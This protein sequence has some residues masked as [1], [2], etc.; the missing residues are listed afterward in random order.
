MADIQLEIITPEKIAY[1]DKVSMVS[2][3][4]SDGTVGVLPHHVPLFTKLVEG[5]VKILKGNEEIY[6]AIG[7]GFMEVTLNKV[8][9]LVTAAYH[10]DEINEQEVTLAK[11]RAEEALKSKPT[12]E[13][14]IEA[15]NLFR[16]SVVALKVFNK[17]HHRQNRNNL[18][19]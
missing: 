7:G 6:L 13:A 4:S 2:A 14:L 1:T 5:E 15:Q 17:R 11:K 12:G 8:V 3:P 18:V 19:S 9:I 10:A 16:R